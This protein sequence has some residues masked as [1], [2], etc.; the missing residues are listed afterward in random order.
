MAGSK[1]QGADLRLTTLEALAA[2]GVVSVET[3]HGRLAV[4]IA[5]GEPFAVSDRC[6]HLGASLGKGHVTDEGCLECPWHHARYDVH[7][8]EMTRGP[9]GLAFAAARGAVK[10][11]TNRAAR[12][13][14]YPVIERDGVLYLAESG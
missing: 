5:G 3:P 9:Q 1:E 14:R 2:T 11:I 8:G 12:L 13:K 7:T 6:R 4:G 10:T